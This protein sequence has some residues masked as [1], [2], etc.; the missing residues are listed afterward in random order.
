M[1]NKKIRIGALILVFIMMMTMAFTGC[2]KKSNEVTTKDNLNPLGVMP[3][4]KDK[5]TLEIMMPSSGNVEDYD[6]NKYTLELEKAGN[7]E[8][9]FNLLSPADSDTVINLK[10]SSGQ[11]LPDI[12]NTPLKDDVVATYG[13]AGLFVILNDYYANSSYYLKPQLE[14]YEKE[15]GV[16]LLKYIT[17]SDGNIYGIIKYNESLQNEIPN[18]L[19][20]NKAW[21]A[22]AGM[23]VPTTLDEFTAALT[24]FKSHDMNGNG[25]L[26]EIPMVDY[27]DG[28]MLNIIENAFVRTGADEITIKADG[29]L[30]MAYATEGYKEFLK[31]ANSL[32]SAGL[33]DPVTF[34]QDNATL[35]TLLNGEVTRVGVFTNTSTS[36]LTAGSS[37][38]ENHEYAPMFL[39]NPAKP[40]Y[41]TFKYMQTMPNQAMFITKDCEYPETAFRIAD[42]MCSE[43]MT[44][45]SRWGE[46]GT[47][48]LAPT[49]ETKGMYEFIGAPAYLEPVLQWGSKQNSHWYNGTPGFRR[50][51]VALGM[52]SND[53]S[54]QSKAF[55]IEELHKRY[56]DP[57]WSKNDPNTKLFYEKV[58]NQRVYKLVYTEEELSERADII[59]AIDPYVKQMRY[60]FITGKTNIDAGWAGYIKEL[61]GMNVD[62]LNDINNAAY[63]RM[64]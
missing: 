29:T 54:Q 50:A 4:S 59:N 31:Y 61:K 21:L 10:L 64:K 11:D 32:Y 27:A 7:V 40:G 5:V 34:S 57:N 55:A 17:M 63:N 60:E 16:N 22:K 26:D 53:A 3:F 44:V 8:L 23:E 47:D 1:Q 14:A 49:A 62:R 19:W 38:R 6:T 12:I 39:D 13:S 51:N 15:T 20:I 37:R 56:S 25:T 36:I 45:W 9:K 2:G 28:A 52:S 42:Y 18:P 30:D 48:W 33:I 35:R 58:L 43:K 24:Y 46:E 41:S